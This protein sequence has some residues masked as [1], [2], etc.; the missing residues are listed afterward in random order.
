MRSASSR[1]ALRPSRKA[2]ENSGVGAVSST[3]TRMCTP[4]AV[5]VIV[6]RLRMVVR[7]RCR[8]TVTI[9]VSLID[10]V[11][12][13]YLMRKGIGPHRSASVMA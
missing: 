12:A 8:A 4:V 1:W 11:S 7:G 5:G 13:K 10:S 6:V 3:S 2:K 9:S